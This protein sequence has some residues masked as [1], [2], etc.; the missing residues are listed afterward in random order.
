MPA[1]GNIKDA[2]IVQ[3]FAIISLFFAAIPVRFDAAISEARPK[4]NRPLTHPLRQRPSLF[5]IEAAVHP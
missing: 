4:S 5:G 2:Q 3:N 1:C